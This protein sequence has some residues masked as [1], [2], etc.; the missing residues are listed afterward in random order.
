MGFGI[1]F[2]GY[3]IAS[4]LSINPFGDITRLIGF[5]I[6]LF[7]LVKLSPHAK[8]FR[9]AKY[10]SLA[11]ILASGA[12]GALT[13]AERFGA[14][15]G[16]FAL[17]KQILLYSVT[18]LF[19][20]F[21]LF[22]LFGIRELARAVEL[23]KLADKALRN[24]IIGSFYFVLTF[25]GSLDTPFKESFA[26]YLGLPTLVIGLVWYI[27]NA[28]LIYSCYMWIC[29]EGDENM[30]RKKSRFEFVNKINE[31][32]DKKEENAMKSTVEYVN[33]KKNKK[34]KK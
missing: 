31:A 22:L 13:L 17:T 20:A 33:S 11:L 34:K 12:S 26:N 3:L 1:L 14:D 16:A 8:G 21:H 28:V 2:I 19:Y 9:A 24:F 7:A 10:F 6:I 25:V 32:L 27:L 4:V 18:V 15:V 30:E 5:S 23:S 29:L